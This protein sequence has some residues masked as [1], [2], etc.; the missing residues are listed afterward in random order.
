MR[1]MTFLGLTLLSITFMLG[2]DDGPP[3]GEVSGV[4]TIDGEPMEDVT[5]TF[6]PADG[7]TAFARTDAAGNYELRY[8]GGKAGAEL[9]ENIVSVETGHVGYD[10]NE[11]LVE[12]PELLPPKFNYES[13]LTRVVEPGEQQFDFALETK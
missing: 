6:T 3:L 9:G 1:N 4:I 5:I 2:C 12:Y 10:E 11:E 13:E 8:S 7:R